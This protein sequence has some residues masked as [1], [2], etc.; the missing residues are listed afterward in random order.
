MLTCSGT[1]V[2]LCPADNQYM[3]LD[4]NRFIP[5]E[6]L[7]DNL[8]TVV[9]QIPGLVKAGDVTQTLERGYWPSYNVPFFREVQRPSDCFSRRVLSFLLPAFRLAGRDAVDMLAIW[10]CVR[11]YL[12]KQSE[13]RSSVCACGLALPLLKQTLERVQLSGKRK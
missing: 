5:G 12:F 2:F 3:V 10:H 8:L 13:L 6:P 4:M 9:E 1:L 11:V 7:D